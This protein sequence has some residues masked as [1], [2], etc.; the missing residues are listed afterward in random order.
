MPKLLV[1]SKDKLFRIAESGFRIY[2]HSATGPKSEPGEA[3]PQSAIRN[4][5]S[6][7]IPLACHIF[8]V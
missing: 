1:C 7:F 2:D 8:R 4:P 5:Q 3:N 6:P